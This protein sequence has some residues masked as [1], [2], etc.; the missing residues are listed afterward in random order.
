MMWSKGTI[1]KGRNLEVGGHVYADLTPKL[2]GRET[3]TQLVLE[4]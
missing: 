1:G 4:R 3:G 2:R